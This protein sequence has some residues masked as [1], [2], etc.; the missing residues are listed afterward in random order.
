MKRK[1][2]VL[3]LA[4]LSLVLL[5]GCCATLWR[6]A[7][8]PGQRGDF[9]TALFFGQLGSLFGWLFIV[10][11]LVTGALWLPKGMSKR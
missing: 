7:P 4:V 1:L 10:V 6:G 3:S 11:D 2:M 9:D 8:P 5:N